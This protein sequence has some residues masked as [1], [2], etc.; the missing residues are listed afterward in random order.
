MPR[1]PAVRLQ[2]GVYKVPRFQQLLWPISRSMLA[3]AGSI[4]S[5]LN[6]G[7]RSTYLVPGVNKGNL[8]MK[9]RKHSADILPS[10][11]S[12][13]RRACFCLFL[14][15]IQSPARL[16]ESRGVQ[17]E[18]TRKRREDLG[19]FKDILRTSSAACKYDDI[20]CWMLRTGP[21]KLSHVIRQT[22]DGTEANPW[23]LPW[24]LE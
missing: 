10:L 6:N 5:A 19:G 1:E 23:I 13:Q 22:S 9:H 4:D 15:L 20:G 24:R 7:N 16:T 11:L 8:I 3:Q 21:R 18:S 14:S 12:K 2:R 17:I